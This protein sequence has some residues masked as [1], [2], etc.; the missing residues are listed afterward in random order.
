[1]TLCG[2]SCGQTSGYAK[3]HS[4]SSRNFLVCIAELQQRVPGAGICA[5]HVL[6]LLWTEEPNALTGNTNCLFWKNLTFRPARR[7]AS[8]NWWHSSVKDIIVC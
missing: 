8:V 3:E 4:V 5:T 1:M 7:A 2:G 6:T